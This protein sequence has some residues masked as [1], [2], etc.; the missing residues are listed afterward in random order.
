MLA[1]FWNLI[2]GNFCN[3]QWE[4]VET[5]PVIENGTQYPIYRKE[6]CRCSKCGVMRMWKF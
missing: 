2:V 1:W 4:H 6:I 5:R 3:H